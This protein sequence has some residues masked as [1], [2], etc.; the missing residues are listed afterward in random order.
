MAPAGAL[1]SLVGALL[2]FREPSPALLAYLVGGAVAA[3]TGLVVGGI[4][5][6]VVR[7]PRSRVSPGPSAAGRRTAIWRRHRVPARRASPRV[8]S[9]LHPCE[10][11]DLVRPR[12]A[13]P[14]VRA[15]G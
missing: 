12:E 1:L 6:G 11:H 14:Y 2:V 5:G 10:S 9:E 7:R 3:A 8:M 13:R 4:A 15:T